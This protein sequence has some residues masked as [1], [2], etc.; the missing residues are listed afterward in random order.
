MR[1]IDG[2][3]VAAVMIGLAIGAFIAL[4]AALMTGAGHGWGSAMPSAISIVACPMAAL[5]WSRWRKPSGVFLAAAALAIGIA[6]DIKIYVDTMNE[7]LAYVRKVGPA[8]RLLWGLPF[9]SWQVLAAV[10]LL[11]ACVRRLLPPS[12]R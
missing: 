3:D 6:T 10:V 12:M 11:F 1:R 7:G 9:A 2:R 4:C 5:A 8:P